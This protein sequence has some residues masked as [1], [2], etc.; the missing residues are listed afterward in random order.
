MSREPAERDSILAA[1]SLESLGSLENIF[2]TFTYGPLGRWSRKQAT[3]ATPTTMCELGLK[4]CVSANKGAS[5]I[6]S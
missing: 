4:D 5:G 1:Q 3:P 6:D 2:Q